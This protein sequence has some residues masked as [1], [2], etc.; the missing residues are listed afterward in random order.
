MPPSLSTWCSAVETG[1]PDIDA[2]HRQLFD[3]AA[4]FQGDGDQVRVMRSLAALSS[5]ANTHLRDEER[6]LESIGYA[7]L[8]AH[9]Q[10]HEKF[11]SMLRQLLEDARGLTLDQI[12]TRIAELINGWFYQ[13]ILTVDAA[14]VD[15]VREHQHKTSP[16]PN[17]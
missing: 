9:R 1:L 17:R 14:Y 10:E 11:R 6:L 3:M 2:Q 4:A 5:Y 8:E 15:S 7:A 13:H 16:L 12:A